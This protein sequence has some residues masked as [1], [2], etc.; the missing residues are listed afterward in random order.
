MDQGSPGENPK[1]N[2]VLSELDWDEADLDEELHKA[3]GGEHAHGFWVLILDVKNCIAKPSQLV[4][5]AKLEEL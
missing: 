5:V 3:G 4:Y 2:L 1:S